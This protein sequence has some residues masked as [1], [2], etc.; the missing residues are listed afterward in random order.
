MKAETDNQQAEEIKG[1][2]IKGIIFVLGKLFK[3]LTD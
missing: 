3:Q 1:F 2:N